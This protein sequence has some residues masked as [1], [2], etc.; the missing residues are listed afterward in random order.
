MFD[1]GKTPSRKRF[2][3]G[4]FKS[5]TP[6]QCIEYL[7][8]AAEVTL[9]AS[10]SKALLELAHA[11]N[12]IVHFAAPPKREALRIIAFRALSETADFIAT[13]LKLSPEDEGTL[14]MINAELRKLKEY[15]DKRLIVIGPKLRELGDDVYWCPRCTH[16]TLQSPHPVACLLCLEDFGAIQEVYEYQIERVAGLSAERNKDWGDCPRCRV[17]FA[18]RTDRARSTLRC[19]GCKIEFE[20]SDMITCPTC[21]EWFSATNEHCPYCAPQA[22]TP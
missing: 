5:I 8:E 13:E 17:P 2:I 18:V 11:R 9:G 12:R 20:P 22:R 7:A 1:K 6:E 19:M 10:A 21:D 14:A 4:D 16:R 3:S 15:L